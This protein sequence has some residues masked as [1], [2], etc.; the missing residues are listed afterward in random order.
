[1]I[2]LSEQFKY[3]NDLES[4][5]SGRVMYHTFYTSNVISGD[6]KRICFINKACFSHVLPGNFKSDRLE[7]K[8]RVY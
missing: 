4:T 5:Y 8:Y 2:K 6:F 1:M 7:G 3:M